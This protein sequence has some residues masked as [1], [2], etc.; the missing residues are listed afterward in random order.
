MMTPIDLVLTANSI[1]IF[2][3]APSLVPMGLDTASS[4]WEHF[5]LKG[6]GKRDDKQPAR[7]DLARVV[8]PVVEDVSLIAV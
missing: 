1:L 4:F 8:D 2:V 3:M 6:E 7:I 5:R